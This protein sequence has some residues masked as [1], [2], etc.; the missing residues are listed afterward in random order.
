[1]NNNTLV[2]FSRLALLSLIMIYT[3]DINPVKAAVN[4][5]W[6]KVQVSLAMVKNTASCTGHRLYASRNR[7]V[8]FKLIFPPELK[9][10]VNNR[11]G[12]KPQSSY[13][14]I[15]ARPK[16]E[17]WIPY[18]QTKAILIDFDLDDAKETD[19]DRLYIELS[20]D[21]AKDVQGPRCV[22]MY[23][24]FEFFL[25]DFRRTDTSKYETFLNLTA[26]VKVEARSSGGYW[27]RVG[28]YVT[29]SLSPLTPRSIAPKLNNN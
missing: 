4:I 15:F 25:V 11:L 16:G 12:G 9:N 6:A 3:G 17:S 28:N 2:R 10:Y 1:M 27:S 8:K 20:S 5:D 21:Y 23:N 14:W 19:D 7:A 22:G 24:S 26:K 13:I 29:A 18:Y